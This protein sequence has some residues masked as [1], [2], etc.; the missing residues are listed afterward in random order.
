M[1][2]LRRE[3]PHDEAPNAR[4]HRAVAR[5]TRPV[6]LHDDPGDRTLLFAILPPL[7]RP[8]LLR[9]DGAAGR[10]TRTTDR[11]HVVRAAVTGS[12]GVDFGAERRS[13]DPRRFLDGTRPGLPPTVRGVPAR[14]CP[15]PR[16][17]RIPHVAHHSGHGE[18]HRR[19]HR[20]G[21][22]TYPRA[23]ARRRSA[24]SLPPLRTR[25]RRGC[26]ASGSARIPPSDGDRRARRILFVRNG[27]RGGRPT[28]AGGHRLRYPAKR[29]AEP[30]R[31]LYRSHRQV[32]TTT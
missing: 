26:R 19:L 32:R 27:G 25:D 21:L 23:D 6:R 12:S 20:H 24:R 15:Q 7:G 18:T 30:R 11:A 16:H 1:S 28:P 22:R 10:R 4:P 5:R 29:S 14:L 2:D 13:D 9:T 17:D 3:H 31:R 8:G